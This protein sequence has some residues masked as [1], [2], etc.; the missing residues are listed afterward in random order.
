MM[1]SLFPLLIFAIIQTRKT[2]SLSL[3]LS[4]SQKHPVKVFLV[5]R[6]CVCDSNL[7]LNQPSAKFDQNLERKK[8][9]RHKNTRKA[10]LKKDTKI[11]HFGCG[12][13]DK[14]RTGAIIIIIAKRGHDE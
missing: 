10:L 5:T 1:M 4:F 11:F 12:L 9:E 2:T 3:S 7:V 13:P 14:R 8:I 6:V